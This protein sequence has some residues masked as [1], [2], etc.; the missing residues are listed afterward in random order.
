MGAMLAVAVMAGLGRA[1]AVPVVA[2]D[3]A[4]LVIGISLGA[5]IDATV[6]PQLAGWSV[7]LLGL[8]VALV[9]TM[10]ASTALLRGSLPSTGRPRCWQARPAPCR[11]RWRSRSRARAMPRR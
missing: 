5:G 4:F 11:T 10:A 3:L 2:R 1:V 6:L 9:A 7:S 8:A